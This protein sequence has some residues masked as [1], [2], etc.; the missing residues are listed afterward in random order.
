MSS[1][2]EQLKRRLSGV[3]KGKEAEQFSS[4]QPPAMLGRAINKDNVNP[5]AATS[6]QDAS[7]AVTAQSLEEITKQAYEEG[8]QKG[9]KAGTDEGLRQ[10]QD[11][12][13]QLLSIIDAL[14]SK[15]EEFDEQITEQLVELTTT[16][17]KQVIRKEL[18]L[19]SDAILTLVQEVLTV[20]PTGLEKMV[21]KLNPVDAKLVNDAYKLDESSV[22]GWRL[23]EDA[24]IQQGGCILSSDFSVINAELEQRIESVLNQ[25]LGPKNDQ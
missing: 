24:A 3:I 2:E 5:G 23:I 15:S 4:W 12:I 14:K 1:T 25:L 19:S 11:K 17:A 13:T 21:L 18:S 22:R 16:I 6:S 8:F 7:D 10:Q 20:M 9:I